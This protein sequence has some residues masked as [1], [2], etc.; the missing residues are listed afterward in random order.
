MI[1]GLKKKI[2]A[3]NRE[4]P[5]REFYD[6]RNKV[7]LVRNAR[8]IGDILN[9]RMLFKQ[10]KKMM[11]EV[12]LT[13]ACFQ[14]YRE[15]VEDHPCLDKVIDIDSICKD[16]YI[17]SYDISRCCIQYESQIMGNNKKHRADIWAESCGITLDSHD[18]S[19]PFISKEKIQECYLKI[20]NLYARKLKTSTTSVP[21]IAP[22]FARRALLPEGKSIA[23]IWNTESSSPLAQ[24]KNG[25]S[26]LFAPLAFE[27]MRSLT[28]PLLEDLVN[29]LREKG[30]F[31]YTVH[32]NNI[33]LLKSLDVPVVI[34]KKLADW[35]G[36]IHAADYV[37]SV[38]T[39]TF[40]YAGGIGKPL[41]GIFT[42]VDGKLR[43]K[44]YDFV[45][46]QKHKDNGDWPCGP[47]YN[48]LY[49]TNPKCK[50]P[51]SLDDLRP[52]VTELTKEETRDGVDKMLSRWSI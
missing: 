17:L 44:Y 50:N 20:K 11:P 3:V 25:P 12:D 5:I 26:V 32:T 14:E 10:F 47:C 24:N 48:Y 4:V 29:Y 9:C 45:L 36:Y 1:I 46:V 7:L 49:C 37:I 15:L 28:Q 16:D 34:G 35:M 19:L 40:H 43:G 30:L 31:V 21:D 6:K 8:G 39:G 2:Q 38:D 52:C 51:S 22:R 27:K 23:P 13:F 33:P 41:V 18:M 42:H